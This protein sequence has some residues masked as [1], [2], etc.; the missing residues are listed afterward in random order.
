MILHI[1]ARPN[2]SEIKIEKFGENRYLVFLKSPAENN[3]AN[4]ELLK[5]M[6]KYLGIPSTKIKIIS[7]LLSKDKILEIIY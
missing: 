6:G 5:V 4:I 7:G 3:E 2:S 1:R